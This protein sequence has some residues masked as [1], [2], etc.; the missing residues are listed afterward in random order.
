MKMRSIRRTESPKF[1][2]D[3]MLNGEKYQTSR[4]K[5]KYSWKAAMGGTKMQQAAE[6]LYIITLEIRV[7]IS[8][9]NHEIARCRRCLSCLG[10][11]EN[12]G[13]LKCLEYWSHVASECFDGSNLRLGYDSLSLPR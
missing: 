1:H 3:S 9:I 8:A 11:E 5:V 12:V 6:T 4:E 13:F 2:C 7:R 10:F